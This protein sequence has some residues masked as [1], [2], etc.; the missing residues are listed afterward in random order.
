MYSARDSQSRT[1]NITVS[2]KIMVLCFV[3][4]SWADFT[5]YVRHTELAADRQSSCTA[6]VSTVYILEC[7][8][9]GADSTR[10]TGIHI[11]IST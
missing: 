6:A 1:S 9:Y 7:S 2:R 10:L 4:Y 8:I 3:L 5:R 11:R